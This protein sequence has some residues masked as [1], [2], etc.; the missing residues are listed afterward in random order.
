MIHFGEFVK[1]WIFGQTVLPDRSL[2]IAQKL[3]ENTEIKKFND[4]FCVIFKHC[5]FPE[6][7]VKCSWSSSGNPFLD[8]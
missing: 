5:A 8:E 4:T 2:E 6:K 3:A 1:T 7:I